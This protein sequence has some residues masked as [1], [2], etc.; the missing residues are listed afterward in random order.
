M[1]EW[2]LQWLPV[3]VMLFASVMI[4]GILC[5]ILVLVVWA[6]ILMCQR[7]CDDI[8]GDPP[9]FTLVKRT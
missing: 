5:M 9:R 2:L 4:V 3:T 1:I 7:C 8:H 6:L